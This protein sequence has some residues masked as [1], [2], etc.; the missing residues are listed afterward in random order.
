VPG[1]DLG[2]TGGD[3]DVESE[4]RRRQEADGA[5][6]ARVGAV[7]GHQA[8]AAQGV[9]RVVQ[10]AEG[11]GVG[12]V[13]DGT[14]ALAE[15]PRERPGAAGLVGVGQHVE[16]QGCAAGELCHQPQLGQG[17]GET[18]RHAVEEA[19]RRRGRRGQVDGHH[20]RAPGA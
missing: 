6:D 9:V 10:R 5:H 16:G 7:V 11:V 2:G 18:P 4:P 8:A 20:V 15:A 19:G 14:A 3:V 13:L 17:E 12:G 1:L